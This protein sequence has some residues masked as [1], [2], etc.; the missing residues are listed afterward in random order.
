MCRNQ[1]NTTRSTRNSHMFGFHP[2]SL[3]Q[4][5]REHRLGSYGDPWAPGRRKIAMRPFF[6]G[7]RFF[8]LMVFVIQFKAPNAM[9]HLKKRV[10]F[11]LA[12]VYC[13]R[14]PPMCGWKPPTC[15][16]FIWLEEKLS[17]GHSQVHPGNSQDFAGHHRAAIDHQHSGGETISWICRVDVL[18]FHWLFHHW[19]IHGTI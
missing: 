9:K 6:D 2:L 3:R 16:D 19:G 14:A 5:P 17:Q 7:K 11:C 4:T 12:L 18:I 10:V 8:F 15:W 13:E 1:W